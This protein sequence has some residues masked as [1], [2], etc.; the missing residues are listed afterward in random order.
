MKIDERLYRTFLEEMEELE[1]FRL[2]YASLHPD[3]PLDHEDPDVK[4]LIEAMALFSARTRLAG[5][6]N[7][8]A[9][10]RRIFQQFFP[11]LL[12]PLPSMAIIQ[13]RP[14]GQLAETV[15]LPRGSEIAVTPQSGGAAIFR[16]LQD[17]RML[18]I[19][20][21]GSDMLQLSDKRV[22]LI[23][24]FRTPFPR[25]DEI[26][27]L[28]FH[29]NYL[30]N[31]ESSQLVV[32]HLKHHL[33]RALV[34]FDEKVTETTSGPSCKVSFGMPEQEDDFT[35]PLEQERLFFHFPRQELFIHVEVPAPPRNW[36][37]FTLCF[38]LDRGWP[39]NLVLSQ[40]FF[41]LFAAPI[42]NLR[43]FMAQPVTC[44]GTKESYAIRNPELE[45]GFDLHS[46]RGVYE[47]APGGMIP[48]KPGILSGGAPSYETEEV[49]D[50]QGRKRYYLNLHFPQ[51]F[52][53]PKTIATEALWIQSWFSETI[54]QRLSVSPFG[55]SLVGLKWEL[56]V[57]PVP[58]AEN[59]LQENIDGFLHFLTLTNREALNRDDL[60]DILQMIGLMRQGP[61]KRICDLLVDI[62]LEKA[63]QQGQVISGLLKH[64]YVLSFRDYDPA[65]EPMME[66]FLAH[67]ERILDAW[68][69]GAKIKVRREVMGKEG[70]TSQGKEVQ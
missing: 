16:T 4:R 34:V 29:I 7:I 38:D 1:N 17:L 9:T 32:Y 8:I 25:S 35:H 51:A 10:R 61:F 42:I 30:N 12:T 41:Q 3:V 40:E 26:G 56:L 48:I 59:L 43:Q 54:P 36:T 66:P 58:H 70:L 2:A 53:E 33:R 62:R 69:S 15:F 44:N 60:L 21:V 50:S 47:V 19:S 23:L 31:Y 49:T 14:T 24:S 64:I 27:Q 45:A 22:R 63:S 65:L 5:T 46:V 20:P 13:A 37:T 28:S 68:I 18:P 6:R 52:Q 11:Y 39:R 67:V 55:R 57:T